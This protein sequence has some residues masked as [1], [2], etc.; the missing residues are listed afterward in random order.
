[1]MGCLELVFFAATTAPLPSY[2]SAL[3]DLPNPIRIHF[4][5][6]SADVDLVRGNHRMTQ[7]TDLKQRFEGIERRNGKFPNQVLESSK[8][9]RVCH[10]RVVPG[11]S[12]C[13]ALPAIQWE[14]VG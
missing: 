8:S 2:L 12:I 10:R 4:G 3:Y 1:M 6:G 13:I 14:R 9:V 11:N 7:I 5:L